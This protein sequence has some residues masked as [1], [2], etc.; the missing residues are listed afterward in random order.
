[1]TL[2]PPIEAQQPLP[3]PDPANYEQLVSSPRTNP[4]LQPSQEAQQPLSPP[5]PADYEQPVSSPHTN[6]FLQPTQEAHQPLPPPQ[7]QHRVAALEGFSLDN[8][9]AYSPITLPAQNSGDCEGYYNLGVKLNDGDKLQ[10]QYEN[11]AI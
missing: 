8:N 6:P 5:D 10:L 2:Q 1:M 7:P 4:F 11:V 9:P 3:P